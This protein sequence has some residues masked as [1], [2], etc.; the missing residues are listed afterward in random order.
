MPGELSSS[1]E[2]IWSR[3]EFALERGGVYFGALELI[4]DEKKLKRF[5][6]DYNIAIQS[7]VQM[8]QDL[9]PKHDQIPVY[10]RRS[11]YTNRTDILHR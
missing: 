10:L 9:I 2:P 7:L 1:V 5:E 11:E 6:R 8:D 4:D 3:L